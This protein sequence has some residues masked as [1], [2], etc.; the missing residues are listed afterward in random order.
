MKTTL[1]CLPCFLSQALHTI[2]LTGA[3]TIKQAQ[4]MQG[5][6]SYLAGIDLTASPPENAVGLYRLI[7]EVT[8]RPDP[9]S[10]LKRQSNQLAL[11]LVTHIRRQIK[12]ADDP[13]YAALLF[14][15]AG[16]IIDYGARHTFD[17]E[18]TIRAALDRDPAINE[19]AAFSADL[20]R[21]RTVLY[22]GDNSG[23]LVFDGLVIEQL[24]R[25]VIFVVKESPIINDALHTDAIACGL[26][27]LCRIVSNGTDCPGTPL[28]T[29]SEEFRH[30][31]HTADLIISKGQGNFET[32]SEV[33]APLYFLLTVK[34]PVVGDHIRALT[35]REVELGRTV[36]LKGITHA[37]P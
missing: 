18:T 12:A 6:L 21:A 5:A 17:I 32:L 20:G 14:S 2:R 37:R 36:L 8:A 34:C 10:E 13:L 26:N 31:F 19:Y 28:A 24:D 11:D 30:L 16:N 33:K 35:G 25:E 22:L 4:A 7:A 15:L 3:D 29:C 9:F 27:R 23:E 1:D